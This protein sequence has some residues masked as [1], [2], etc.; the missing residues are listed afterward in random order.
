VTQALTHR[1]EVAAVAR[2]PSQAVLE[3]WQVSRETAHA[4]LLVVSELVINAVEH[5]QPPLALH[6]YCESPGTEV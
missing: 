1:P 2:H 6:L 5:A 3:A 4:A